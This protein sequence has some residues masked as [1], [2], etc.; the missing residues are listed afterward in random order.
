MAF[1]K[2]KPFYP[3]N[4]KKYVG[5]VA[6]IV[7]RSTWERKVCNWCDANTSV[8]HWNSEEIVIDYFSRADNKMR[9]Y[10]VDFIVK[11]IGKDGKLK[12][13]LIEVKPHHECHPPKATRGKTKKRLMQET[14]TYMVNQDKWLHA[15]EYAA[16]HGME[17]VV[18][19][20]HE[21]GIKGK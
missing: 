15:R 6:N 3:K 18:L 11:M 4:P 8:L 2:P 20:E 5:D 10:F 21:L 19:T 12:T 13:L 14:Y 7:C 17:F 16:K 1:P 9:R